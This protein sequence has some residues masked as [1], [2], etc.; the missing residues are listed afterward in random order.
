MSFATI[1]TATLPSVTANPGAAIS[2]PLDVTGFSNV[3]SIALNITIDPAV[4]SFTGLSNIN[5]LTPGLTAFYNAATTS[6]N[7]AWNAASPPFPTINGTLCK[8][9]FVY[10]GPGTSALAFAPSCQVT[11]GTP[12]ADLPVNF[13]DGQVSPDMTNAAHATLA[14]RSASIGQYI[15]VPLTFTGFPAAAPLVGGITQKITFDPAILTFVNITPHGTLAGAL[16]YVTGNMLT[17]EWSNPSGAV[18]NGPANEIYLNFIYNGPGNTNISF[19]PGC[20]ISNTLTA[21]IGVNYYNSTITQEAT[22]ITAVLGSTSANQG[23]DVLIPLTLTNM[24]A[25]TSA[26]TLYINY[27]YPKL[28]FVGVTANTHGALVNATSSHITIEWEDFSHPDINGVFLNLKFHYAGVG[29]A[30]INFAPGCLFSDITLAP[31]NVA[32]TNGTVSQIPVVPNVTIAN[33]SAQPDTD[34]DVPVNFS[35]FSSNVGAVSIY[36]GYDNT[37]LTPILPLD[38]AHNP[39]NASVWVTGGNQV[40]VLWNTSSLVGNNLNG[41]FIKLKFHY[42]GGGATPLIF[43]P[44]C[45]IADPLANIIYVNWFNGSVSTNAKVSGILSYDSHPNPFLALGNVT[46]YLKD[47][48]EPVPPATSPVPNIL[49]STTTDANGYFEFHVPNGVYF[50]YAHSTDAWAG[51]GVPDVLNLRRYAAGLTPNTIDGDPLRIRTADI[52]QDGFVDVADV[53]PLRRQIAGLVPNPNWLIP[54]WLFENP[55]ITVSGTDVIQNLQGICSGDVNG[56]Y[57]DPN[58]K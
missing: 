30:H 29:T 19:A 22:N 18:I 3:G 26:L 2:L 42:I 25:T 34:V 38:A 8:L 48:A 56:S 41:D 21:N 4:L 37:K 10:N 33:A 15:T 12:P 27:E 47:G 35:S 54:D 6:V 50:V 17:I 57:P 39:Y 40:N 7:I 52:N 13:T 14:S 1:A 20:I 46:V 36:I 5:A 58:S 23:D 32:F 28:V 31:I 24:P 9:N 49:Y 11:T 44:G 43:N 55:T 16:A 51:V 45:E 53:L